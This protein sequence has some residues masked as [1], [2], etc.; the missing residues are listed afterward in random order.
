MRTKQP[1]K[2]IQIVSFWNRQAQFFEHRF[3]MLLRRLLTQK[4]DVVVKRLI[5]LGRLNG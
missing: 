2:V 5:S 3:E 4:T 1:K